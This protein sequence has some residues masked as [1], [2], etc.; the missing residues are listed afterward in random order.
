MV[1]HTSPGETGKDKGPACLQGSQPTLEIQACEWTMQQRG[2]QYNG[3]T[4]EGP[5]MA[6]K[7]K[8]AAKMPVNGIRKDKQEFTVQ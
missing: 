1:P 3:N 5:D 7:G 8:G 2:T 4:T 6:W